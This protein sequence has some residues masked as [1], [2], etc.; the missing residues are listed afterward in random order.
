M[1][2]NAAALLELEQLEVETL[3]GFLQHLDLTGSRVLVHNGLVLDVARP[4]GVPGGYW[5]G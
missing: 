3:D 2:H 4:V 1:T 5:T